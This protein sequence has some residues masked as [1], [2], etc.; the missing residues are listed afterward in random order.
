MLNIPLQISNWLENNN[1]TPFPFQLKTWREYL[2]GKSGLIHASTGA[3]KTYAAYLGSVIEFLNSK[4]NK[5]LN[6]LQVLWITPLRALA[7]DTVKALTKPLVEIGLPWSVG[8][9]TGDT[10]SYIKSKQAKKL[11]EVLVTTPE[12]LSILFSYSGYTSKF[13]DLKCIIIDEW[14]EL[15]SSKRGVLTEL[16][17]ARLKSINPQVR[18]WGLSATLGNTPEAMKTLLGNKHD[19]GILIQG[20]VS[21]EII[22]KTIIPD[23]VERFPW[24]GHLGTLLVNK[25]IDEIENAATSLVFTNTRSQTE[26]WFR[27]ILD[28]RPDWAGLIALHH[29]SLDK[30]ERNVVEDFLRSGKVKCVVCTS[31]LDLGVDFSPVDKVI[32]IGS[33]KG[34]ARM[35]Q[36]AGRSGHNPGRSSVIICVPSNSFD[37]IEFAAV[38]SAVKKNFIEPRTSLLNSLDVLSQHL[39]TIAAGEGFNYKEMFEEIKSTNAFAK[40]SIEEFDWV[41]FFITKGGPALRAYEEYSKV[42]EKDG[43]YSIE[44]KQIAKRHRMSIGTI[45]GDSSVL[46]KYLK[47]SKL[48]TIEEAFI[49]KLKRGD[50]FAFAGRNL[51][52]VNLKDMTAYVRTAKTTRS[53]IP[54]WWGGRLPLSSELALEVRLKLNEAKK[55]IYDSEEM[56]SLRPLLELQKKWSALPDMNELLIETILTREGHHIFIYPFE[57]KLVHEGLAS[58]AAYRFGKIIPITFSIST[59]DYG[60]ELLSRDEIILNKNLLDKVFNTDE[61]IAD[62]FE[63]L[64]AS[65]MA[66]RQFREIARIAGLVFQ[67]YPG[68]NKPIK[69]LQ[70]SSSMFYEVFRKYDPENLFIKQASKEVLQKQLEET[71]LLKTLTRIKKS[72]YLIIEPPHPTPLAFP[73]MVNRFREKISSEKLSDRIKKMQIGLEKASVK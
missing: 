12:S 52:F 26:I 20:D 23:V 58:L 53:I 28:K 45:T 29:G 17:L 44:N 24:A 69:H 51:E 65:E 72:R 19:K 56:I 35:L 55:G 37:I 60:F 67:G 6:V 18:I 33:P 63:S 43:Y 27:A 30:D 40:I 4:N 62:I 48:G 13:A 2:N 22:F 15:M 57:G 8:K 5:S 34:V 73:I 54:Q 1:W 46:I 39:V 14:H 66:R 68:S 31:S 7:E 64:N 3:G 49:A 25:V 16:L 50:V 38:R 59:N 61:L 10:S 47:G 32:Q 21:K 11:P 9:R 70:A 41:L 36:R 42:T 71:R